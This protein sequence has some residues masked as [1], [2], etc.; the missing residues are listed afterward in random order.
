MNNQPR[1]TNGMKSP[2]KYSNHSRQNYT[3]GDGNFRGRGN[4]TGG[5]NA[6]AAREK[7]LNQAREALASGDRIL[8]EYYFQH[9]E[10]Y[11]RVMAEEGPRPGTQ[12]R[13]HTRHAQPQDQL[14]E[15]APSEDQATIIPL[16]PSYGSPVNG[17]ALQEDSA[18][19]DTQATNEHPE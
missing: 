18:P 17:A 8:A 11:Y 4:P 6:S 2:R 15:H 1:N 7:Y 19:L 12:N 9:A 14:T 3:Q 16:V 5:R 10:H 13:N